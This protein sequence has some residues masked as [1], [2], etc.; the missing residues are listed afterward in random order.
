MKHNNIIANQHFRKDW[1]RYVR[2]FFNQPGHKKSRRVAR[3]AKN[4]RIFPR[5]PQMLRPVVRC[6]TFKY[7]T[8][9]RLGRG[10]TL[11]ELKAAG[12]SPKYAQTVGICV[13]HRRRNKSVE[14]LQANVQRLKEYQ[15]KLVVI[16]KKKG[17]EVPAVDQLVGTIMPLEKQSKRVRARAITAEEKKARVFQSMR[18]AR[19][20]A[21]LIGVRQR[22]AEEKAAAAAMKK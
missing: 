22:R 8:K 17:A 2:C 18:V 11:D 21:R 3:A 16:P 1:Q 19:A 6:P 7:N 12:I 10:F 20:D 9:Q 14:A 15:N 5:P 13:D 4:A